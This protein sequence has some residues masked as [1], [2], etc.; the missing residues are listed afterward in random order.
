MGSREGVTGSRRDTL[1]VIEEAEE[2]CSE[3]QCGH[4]KTLTAPRGLPR[5]SPNPSGLQGGARA[6]LGED[7]ETRPL[8]RVIREE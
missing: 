8:F 1:W 6:G 5:P 7:E 4:S 3:S 2:G